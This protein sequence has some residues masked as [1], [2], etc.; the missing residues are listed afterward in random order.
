MWKVVLGYKCSSTG[1]SQ[2]DTGTNSLTWTTKSRSFIANSSTSTVIFG[3]D[4]RSDLYYLLDDVSIV[5]TD[6]QSVQLLDNPSFDD[7]TT[8]PVGWSAW[9][10]NT[11]SGSSG[12]SVT[13]SGC[14]SS[15]CYK[16]SCYGG[17]ATDYI[18]QTFSTIAGQ[19]YT[20]SF[21]YRR[22]GSS[23]GSSVYLYGTVF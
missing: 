7:S 22:V 13:T 15:V 20:I 8:N 1:L 6:D 23:S 19:N 4:A 11:C 12:G 17:S 3:F 9:C 16:G 21:Y 5:Q 10:S 18:T 14:R 2:L